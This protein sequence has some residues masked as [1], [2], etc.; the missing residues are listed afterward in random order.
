MEG[1]IVPIK[2]ERI[3]WM[4]GLKGI[5]CL[6]LFILH[7]T[8][9][10]YPA[11]MLG[12]ENISHANGLEVALYNSPFRIFLEGR[13]MVSVFC[14]TSGIFTAFQVMNMGDVKAKMPGILVKK[15]LRLMLPVI[16][17]GIIVW[18]MLKT[19]LFT[20]VAASLYTGSEWLPKFYAQDY[21]IV[22]IM[23]SAI[24]KT[25]FY[26]DDI[27]S[28][29]FWMMTQMFYGSFLTIILAM[30]YW[31]FPKKS[32]LVYVFA[33][34]CFLPRHDY[35]SV[36][37]LAAIFAWFVKEGHISFADKIDASGKL[38]TFIGAVCIILAYFF[39]A[40]PEYVDPVGFYKKLDFGFNDIW[41]YIAAFLL[42]FGI[43]NLKAIQKLLSCKPLKKLGMI[44]YDLVLVH[45]PI[46][47]SLTTSLFM[48]MY[49]KG[50]NYHV[51]AFV[52]LVITIPVV[53]GAS[54]IYNRFVEHGCGIVTDMIIKF[55][56]K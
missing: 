14:L 2:K 10:F 33:F 36:F 9:A 28:T 43:Y 15:Y 41:Y 44:C 35:I 53:I 38:S 23:S 37:A 6:L 19:G 40:Y 56:E 3:E 5:A 52:P 24:V 32:V 29:I 51:A 45:I 26:G 55:M 22:Q 50:M 47:F 11:L 13:V 1:K 42:V 21:S 34:A 16:P 25:W 7:W 8:M 27:I 54:F 39:G 4:D 49:G 48:F 31:K 30:L 46:M 18:I 20:N 17:L 12:G